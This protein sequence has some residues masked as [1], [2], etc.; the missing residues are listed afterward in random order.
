MGIL[1]ADKNVNVAITN[2]FIPTERSVK[3]QGEKQRNL[4]IQICKLVTWLSAL[5]RYLI[6]EIPLHLKAW[7]PNALASSGMKA[8]QT[9]FSITSA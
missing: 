9:R 2:G 8:L 5:M 3:E 7:T 6:V 1:N 4:W